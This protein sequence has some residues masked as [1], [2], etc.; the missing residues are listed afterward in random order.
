MQMADPSGPRSINEDSGDVIPGNIS[1]PCSLTMGLP[2]T[3]IIN[4]V[5]DADWFR[6]AR[7]GE[8]ARRPFSSG[9]LG[10]ARRAC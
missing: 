10:R 7:A 5:G 9:R 1:T 3:G 6:I 2:E 8:V 4:S